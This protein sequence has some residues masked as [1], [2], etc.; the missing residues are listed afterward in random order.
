MT[1]I[2][3]NATSES[4]FVVDL[5]STDTTGPSGA[6]WSMPHGGDLDANLVHQQPDGAIEAHVNSEVDVA[7]SVLSGTGLLVAADVSHSLHRGVF[8]LIPKGVQREIRAGI[9]GLTYLSIHRRR[10]SLRITTD[11]VHRS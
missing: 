3:P 6:V 1:T 8:A 5:G 2:G 9:A 11:R 4:A 10:D 7:V